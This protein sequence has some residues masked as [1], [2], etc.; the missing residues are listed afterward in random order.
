MPIKTISQ[1]VLITAAGI[2]LNSCGGGGDSYTGHIDMVFLAGSD[3]AEDGHEHVI[4]SILCSDLDSGMDQTYTGISTSTDDLHTHNVTVTA[5]QLAVIRG[6][7]TVVV[8]TTGQH[9]HT[10]SFN[11]GGSCGEV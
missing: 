4:L 9:E 2:L 8:R 10:W 5:E 1:F 11:H 6:G 7:G 3:P